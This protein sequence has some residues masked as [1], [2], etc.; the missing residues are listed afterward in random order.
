MKANLRGVL[1]MGSMS[2]LEKF[3]VNHGNKKSVPRE[4]LALLRKAGITV[5]GSFLEIGAGLGYT[6]SVIY[7]RYHPERVVVTDFDAR[8]VRGAQAWIKEKYGFIP[9]EFEFRQESALHLSFDDASFDYVLA[10]LVFHHV[11]SQFW[12]FVNTPLATREVQRVLKPGGLF[13]F[14]DIFRLKKV[15]ALFVKEGFNIM[16]STCEQRIYRKAEN[17]GT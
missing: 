13:I 10:T 9:R 1:A 11:E 5:T 14:R 12:R 7:D 6:S 16:I 15:D 4:V 2:F 17:Q 3:F 8:Q